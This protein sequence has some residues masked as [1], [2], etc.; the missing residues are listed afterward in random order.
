M[1]YVS[2]PLLYPADCRRQRHRFADH[3]HHRERERHPDTELFRGKRQDHQAHLP[4]GRLAD[5]RYGS[6]RRT[7]HRSVA[8]LPATTIRATETERWRNE[9]SLHRRQ[10]SGCRQWMGHPHHHGH[11][12]HRRIGHRMVHFPIR[13]AKSIVETHGHVETHG[14]ASL[15][16]ATFTILTY[17]LE[18]K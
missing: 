11:H 13:W 6:R 9:R 10:L 5:L 3:A 4:F 2:H 7:N 14:R 15:Q 17:V 18:R 16:L 1:D 8:L 12:P